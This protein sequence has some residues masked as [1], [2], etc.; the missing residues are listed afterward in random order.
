MV[1]TGLTRLFSLFVS[2]IPATTRPLPFSLFVVVLPA[3]SGTLPTGGAGFGLD[4][5]AACSSSVCVLN[6][7]EMVAHFG[8]QHVKLA[9]DAQA[10]AGPVGRSVEGM[11]GGTRHP[12]TWRCNNYIFFHE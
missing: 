3:G 1:A 4:F 2:G 8:G 6:S 11:G 5:G 9:L 7:Q 10:C 12:V